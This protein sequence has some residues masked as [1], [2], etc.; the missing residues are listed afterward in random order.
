LAKIFLRSFQ[1]GFKNCAPFH[2]IFFGKSSQIL[3]KTFSKEVSKI[4]PQRFRKRI[5]ERQKAKLTFV[6]SYI[7]RSYTCPEAHEDRNHL[8]VTLI[9]KAERSFH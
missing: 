3:P 8:I 5:T 7:P 2:K 4:W 1:R 6:A 9:K